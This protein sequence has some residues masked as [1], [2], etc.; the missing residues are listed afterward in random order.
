MSRETFSFRV[1]DSLSERIEKAAESR[2]ISK[3]EFVREAVRD[4]VDYILLEDRANL[5]QADSKLLKKIDRIEKGI[6]AQQN[7]MEELVSAFNDLNTENDLDD[8]VEILNVLN[9]IDVS[10][11]AILYEMYDID[12]EDMNDLVN[13]S[14][15]NIDMDERLNIP[16]SPS[17]GSQINS[18]S[19][20]DSAGSDEEDD[21][22]YDPTEDDDFF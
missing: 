22:V 15:K 5:Y 8:V 18:P 14:K 9:T 12:A 4:K 7:S 16:V 10:Q 3:S 6:E 19:N 2:D 1:G 20:D 13:E 11:L 17:D 21:G